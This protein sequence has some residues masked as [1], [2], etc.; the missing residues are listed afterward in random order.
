[1]CSE[2]NKD[3]SEGRQ[4]LIKYGTYLILIIILIFI[5]AAGYEYYH[6]YAEAFKDPNKIKKTVLSYGKYSVFA[7]IL[8]Q[9]TQVIAFFIPGEVI[10]IAGGYIYGTILGGTISLFGITLGSIIVF[11][12]SYLLG[13]SL[14]KKLISKK[15]FDFFDRLL[16]S[17]RIN[18]VV[19]LLYLIPGIPKDVLAY[20]CGIANISFKNFIIYSTLGRIPGI[21]ISAYFGAGLWSGGKTKLVV[22][23][24]LMTILFI[25]GAFKGERIIKGFIKKP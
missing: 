14:I 24:I 17:G 6:S 7:F 9:I 3:K 12:I 1:M 25:I 22:I 11:G 15:Q 23:A 2:K 13:K 20:I 4:K 19:F 18:F 5:I 16:N 8:M 10:Q 21:F